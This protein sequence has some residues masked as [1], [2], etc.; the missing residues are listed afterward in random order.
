MLH[1]GKAESQPNTETEDD[2]MSKKRY[3][4]AYGSNL[5]KAQMQQRCPGA[6]PIGTG[7]LEGYE[8]LF[9]GSKTGCYLTIE[10]KADGVVPI[11]VWEVSAE[12]ERS[13]DRYEGCPV[14]YYKQQ[15]RL[16][17]FRTQSGRT[18][19]TNGFVYIMHENRRLGEPHPRYFWTCVRGY[20]AFGFDPEFLYEAYERSPKG[21]R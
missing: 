14:C 5:N 2:N 18:I 13:L 11:V 17:V 6:K 12:H 4:I 15:M 20:R 19:Q 10:P 7:L 8:L 21:V 9:K 16:P 3:Y 1:N